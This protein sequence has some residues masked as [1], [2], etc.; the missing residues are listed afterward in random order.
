MCYKDRSYFY[1]NHRSLFLPLPLALHKRFYLQEKVCLIALHSKS[2]KRYLY[3]IK[4]ISEQIISDLNV[5]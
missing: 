5:V 3:L 4:N 1:K 2:I